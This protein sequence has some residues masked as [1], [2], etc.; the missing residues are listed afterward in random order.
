MD[1]NDFPELMW[2]CRDYKFEIKNENSGHDALK[3]F[4]KTDFETEKLNKTKDCFIKSF[5]NIDGFFL[6]YPDIQHQNGFS[7]KK[8]L[9]GIENYNWCDLSGEFCDEM[10]NLCKRIKENVQIKIFDKK[11]IKGNIFS[12]F[13]KEVV[14]SLNDEK[15]IFVVDMIEVLI[16]NDSNRILDQIKNNYSNKL[17]TLLS[18]LPKEWEL[19]NSLEEKIRNECLN[20]LKNKIDNL[21][22][23]EYEDLLNHYIL[24]KKEHSG[25]F[26]YYINK[27]KQM[28]E[29][30][31]TE[32]FEKL[33]IEYRKKMDDKLSNRNYCYSF[34]DFENDLSNKIFSNFKE[35]LKFYSTNNSEPIINWN[36]FEEKFKKF[37]DD[38]EYSKK[39]FENYLEKEWQ[40]ITQEFYGQQS[41]SLS[42][43]ESSV[44]LLKEE[45]SK[46]SKNSPV[47]NNCWNVHYDR[48][49]ESLKKFILESEKKKKIQPTYQNVSSPCYHNFFSSITPPSSFFLN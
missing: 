40:K 11:T 33:K 39:I 31:S 41:F 17:K 34:E 28:I 18:E 21:Y 9:L 29:Q 30:F 46:F 13:I 6:P 44:S 3:K 23:N 48:N 49:Y 12:G 4:I 36:L 35:K 1:L 43:F 5:K 10:N 7:S 32:E 2:V 38:L 42:Q 8:L 27:N 16:K 24:N 37:R 26:L 22:I 25:V 47:K 45:Y 14:Q 20:E 15:T 19:M